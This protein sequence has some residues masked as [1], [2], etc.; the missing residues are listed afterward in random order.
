MSRESNRSENSGERGRSKKEKNKEK[1]TIESDDR[2][3][4]DSLIKV[5]EISLKKVIQDQVQP[6]QIDDE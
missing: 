5:N 1:Q 6:S 3:R 4:D 2:E